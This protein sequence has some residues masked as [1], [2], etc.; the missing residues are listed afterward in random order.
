[1]KKS[2]KSS[3]RINKVY[4]RIGDAGKTRLVGGKEC[5]KDDLRVESYGTIDELNAQL[6]LCRELLIAF[7]SKKF[8]HLIDYLY[9]IQNDLFNLGTQLATPESENLI[10]LPKLKQNSVD[11][12]ENEID[13]YNKNLPE[14]NSFI[15]PGGSTICAQFHIA[16]NIC[17]RS[18]RRVVTLSKKVALI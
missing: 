17:R 15:L 18:E 1:M 4:T 3:I 11:N 7:Q 14:L 2:G 12:L 5:D 6:G 9:L 13:S 16:R 10:K 8:S